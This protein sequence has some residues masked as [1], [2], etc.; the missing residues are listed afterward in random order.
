MLYPVSEVRV[1][2]NGLDHPECVAVGRDGTLYAGGERGQVYRIS[3]D[4]KNVK[5]FANTGGFCLGL[6]LDRDENIFVC[7]LRKQ[8]LMKVTQRGAVSLLADAVDG[9]KIR[10][11]NF[12]VFDSQG[13]LYFSD[14]GEW[15]QGNGVVW[16]LSSQG[17]AQLFTAGPFHFANGL[18]LDAQGRY[19]YV[20][21]SNR[22]RV[23]RIEIKSDGSSGEPEVFAEGLARI[24]DGMAFDAA[25]N[26]YVTTYASNCIYR[27]S[28]A[29][30][31][32]L[33]CQDVENLLLCQPTN[34]A[35]GGPN[36]DQL[37]VSNLGRDHISLLD[38]NVKGQ[39]LWTHR[40][41]TK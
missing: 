13:N 3:P 27:V 34:C 23:V 9:V 26:L 11:P 40:A 17:K 12:G 31:V 10:T 37:F 28:T 16:R 25:G 33:L 24:P 14:S 8:A 21:E 7:D 20:V 4:G 2:V 39:P 35:F 32:E 30:H 22:D 38:L 1:L 6:A 36:F 5:E 29:G 19:L 41:A 15:K 18:A